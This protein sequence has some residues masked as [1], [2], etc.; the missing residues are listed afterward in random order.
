MAAV[1]HPSDRSYED[2][3][4]DDTSAALMA[5]GGDHAD[6][7]TLFG[8]LPGYWPV[9]VLQR[10]DS[11]ATTMDQGSAMLAKRIARELRGPEADDPDYGDPLRRLL[12]VPHPLDADWRFT[13]DARN[14]LLDRAA[15]AA[16]G[17]CILLGTP[18]L[19]VHSTGQLDMREVLLVDRSAAT[20]AAAREFAEGH[21]LLRVFQA[22]LA[23]WRPDPA[24]EGQ[25]SVVVADPPWYRPEQTSFLRAASRALRP[26]GLLLMAASPLGTRPAA[27]RDRQLLLDDAEAYGLRLR[28]TEFSLL[29]YT[30]SPFERF[31][32]EAA[33]VAGTPTDWRRADLLVFRRDKGSQGIN[34]CATPAGE[35][36]M[37]I[38]IGRA[39][40][41]VRQLGDQSPHLGGPT[42]H[43]IRPVTPGGTSL[44]VSRRSADRYAANIWTTGNGAWVAEGPNADNEV[45]RSLREARATV[46]GAEDLLD[47]IETEEIRLRSWGWA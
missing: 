6:A 44:S 10:L 33:G 4:L 15:D 3:L 29:P 45:V 39:R 22:D 7:R 13:A 40:V 25:A 8:Y 24:A 41:R 21:S 19:F 43:L 23:D 34:G 16:S 28:E 30:S 11:L 18:T 35:P 36:W 14:L 27:P 32:L 5:L 20:V 47:A 26:G 17:A 46:P 42:T 1:G 12:P 38:A 37:E 31:A 2:R 9:D